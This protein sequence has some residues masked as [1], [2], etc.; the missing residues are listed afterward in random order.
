MILSLKIIFCHKKIKNFSKND[1]I[2][3]IFGA[4]GANI[5]GFFRNFSAQKLG[6]FSKSH[7]PLRPVIPPIAPVVW[8]TY[9]SLVVNV[10]T[11]FIL[12][13]PMIP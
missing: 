10:L 5:L 1:P 6:F 13:T 2:F 11:T 9:P 3:Q 12:Q 7:S 4:Y 8:S